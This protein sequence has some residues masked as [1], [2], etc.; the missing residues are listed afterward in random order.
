MQQSPIHC[1]LTH[2]YHIIIITIVCDLCH[3]KPYVG[4]RDQFCCP[5][6]AFAAQH[7]VVG[8]WFV[9]PWSN[10]DIFSPLLATRLVVSEMTKMS[11]HNNLAL[12]KDAQ[13]FILAH[14]HSTHTH[15]EKQI[16]NLQRGFAI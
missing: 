4:S 9:P 8:F 15:S 12:F 11:C 7:P 2:S 16:L 13:I 6:A 3:S 1:V 10:V 14:P 5:C